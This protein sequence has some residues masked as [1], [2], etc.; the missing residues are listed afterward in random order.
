MWH[1]CKKWKATH[2]TELLGGRRVFLLQNGYIGLGPSESQYGDLVVIIHGV[3]VPFVLR[4][5]ENGNFIL[6]GEAYVHGIMYGE[7]LNDKP[8]VEH[9]TLC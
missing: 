7:W 4:K 2:L 6:V 5:R 9:F 1:Y 3:S 8:V